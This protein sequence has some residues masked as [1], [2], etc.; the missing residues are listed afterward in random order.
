MPPGIVTAVCRR[1]DTEFGPLGVVAS[2][3]TRCIRECLLLGVA[4]QPYPADQTSACIDAL[5]AFLTEPTV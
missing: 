2:V 1:I 4:L 3:G 5:H